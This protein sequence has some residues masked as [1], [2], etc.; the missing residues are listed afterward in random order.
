[1][2]VPRF[3]DLDPALPSV[4]QMGLY[5]AYGHH[6]AQLQFSLSPLRP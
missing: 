4:T 5:F 1:L 6:T 2:Q 3:S